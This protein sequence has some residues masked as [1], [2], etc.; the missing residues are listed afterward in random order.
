MG[1]AS[2]GSG[3]R[4]GAGPSC[5]L[6][7]PGAGWRLDW[8]HVQHLLLMSITTCQE[9]LK[10]TIQFQMVQLLLELSHCSQCSELSIYLCICKTSS[11]RILII[12]SEIMTAMKTVGFAVGFTEARFIL[13]FL[14]FSC[15]YCL[16]TACI[17][18]TSVMEYNV[19]FCEWHNENL[20]RHSFLR[21]FHR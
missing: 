15:T 17:L 20:Y 13:W 6:L 11:P 8:Q 2:A 16:F 10:E 14:L 21:N 3:R 19:S 5:W 7:A 12:T 18:H 4:E 9:A 1:Q